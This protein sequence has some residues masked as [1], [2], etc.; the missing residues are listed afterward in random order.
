MTIALV[1][2]ALLQATPLPSP[3]PV[4]P[5]PSP[6]AAPSLSPAGS[7]L[8]EGSPSAVPSTVPAPALAVAPNAVNFH[9]GEAQ[10]LSVSG[11]NGALSAAIDV[12]VATLTVD[13]NAR[14]VTVSSTQ[15]TG[16]ALVTVTDGTGASV[17]VPVR[18][19]FNAASVP[20]NLTLRITGD[21]VDPQ[22]LQAQVSRAV[23]KV[24]QTQP[25]VRAQLGAFALPQLLAPGASADVPVPIQAAGGD[26]YFDVNTVTTVSVQNVNVAPFDPPLLF[27]DDDP[28]KVIANGVLYRNRVAANSP[29]RLYYYH[30]NSGEQRRIVVVLTP[31]QPNDPATVQLIDASAGPNID[32]M[33]VGHAVSRDFLTAKPHNAG[34]V[35][36][37]GEL[38]YVADDF[39]A[40]PQD[41]LAGSIGINVLSGGPVDV[42]VVAVPPGVS[43]AQIAQYVNQPRL[44]DDG[45]HRT[46]AFMLSGY[47]Q[48]TLSYTVGGDD[49]FTQYG[50][51]T[52]PPADG[53]GR[54]YG[55]YGVLRT[56]TFD[57]NNPTNAAATLYLYEQPL[58]G[59]VRS[60]FL[61]DGQLYQVGCARVS[62][63]YQIGQ[64]VTVNPGSS[65]IVV[66]TMTDGGS[67]YPLGVG[68]TATPPLP[69]TPAI[70]APDGC[71]PKPQAQPAPPSPE[72]GSP[73]PAPSSTP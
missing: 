2:A 25:G 59:V 51:T 24:V 30:Q 65:R 38:P 58:G 46:G 13:Q 11:A 8:P 69:Q 6:S 22:W 3:A 36:D 5:A 14:T 34:I 39:L 61:V 52:P 19:A 44:P 67:N 16:R 31:E 17:Q 7:P 21:A 47:G 62:Q 15:Q 56:L 20:A 1:L 10:T 18:V 27:Y 50:A 49:A 35:A 28:E 9:P 42:A 40:S 66:Q 41:G 45:H 33:S 23:Q 70:S 71:F 12:P 26:Q 72:Q 64:P 63:K 43:D 54:D 37:V 60:S 68:L 4:T 48:E 73:T 32:V 57:V 53:S 29:A 55:D